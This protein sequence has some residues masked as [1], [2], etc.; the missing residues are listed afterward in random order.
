[1][2]PAGARLGASTSNVARE[3]TETLI[4]CRLALMPDDHRCP[5]NRLTARRTSTTESMSPRFNRQ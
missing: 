1:V 2:K 3:L 4:G 5:T